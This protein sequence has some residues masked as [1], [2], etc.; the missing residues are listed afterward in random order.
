[1]VSVGETIAQANS[2]SCQKSFLK[3]GIL[4]VLVSF[5]GDAKH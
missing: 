3:L 5:D 4:N 2:D 1:M